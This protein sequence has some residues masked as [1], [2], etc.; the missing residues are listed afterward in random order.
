MCNCFQIHLDP[1]QTSDIRERMRK[2]FESQSFTDVTF[3]PKDN[4]RVSISAHRAILAISSPLFRKMLFDDQNEMTLRDKLEV[5][6]NNLP[7][8]A[9][10]CIL[11]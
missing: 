4:R 3:Y 2:L 8:D 6:I 1:V 10:T 7:F 11:K 5:Q 9:F